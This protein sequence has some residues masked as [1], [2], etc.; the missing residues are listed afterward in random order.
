MIRTV[1][2]TFFALISISLFSQ[3]EKVKFGDIDMDDLAMEVYPLDSGAEAVYLIRKGES[4]LDEYD[5]MM[6]TDIHVRLKFLKESGLSRGDIE[7]QYTKG[8]N[9]IEKLKAAT[10]NL[11][12]GKMVKRTISKKEWVTEKYDN[13]RRSKKI[14]F[15]DVT[16]GSII[17]YTYRQKIGNYYNMPSWSFQLSIPTVYT[18]FKMNKPKY[19]VY[20]PRIKGYHAAAYVN[21]EG[22]LYHL[23]MKDVPSLE[24]EPYVSTIENFRSKIE[25]ELKAWTIPGEPTQ[26]FLQ[27]WRV[28][29][30]SLLD[31]DGLG[32]AIKKTGQLK[33]IYPA[34]KQWAENEESLKGIY[35]YIRD[36]FEWN[37]YVSYRVVDRSKK[38]W[39]EAKGD[40]ADI[41]IL[42]A[43]FLEKAG[44]EVYPVVL[45]TRSHGYLDKNFPLIKQFNYLI[46]GVIF[47]GKKILLDAT[48]KFRPYNVL[49]TRAMNGEGLMIT[50]FGG[51]WIDLRVNRE[52]SSKVVSLEFNFDEDVETL[53]G[54]A[55]I[56]FKGT[57]ASQIRRGLLNEKQKA[58]TEDSEDEEGDSDVLEDYKTGDVENLEYN[59]LEIPDKSLT[60][61]YDFSSEADINIIG[62]KIFVSP[63]LLKVADENPF[64]LEK[65]LFPIEIPAPTA[66]TY[67]FKMKVPEG[68]EVEELPKSMNMVLP[69]KGG[70]YMFVAGEQNG[71]V[72]VMIRMNLSK[73]MYLPS[74]YP[75]F[76][77]LFNQIVSK[78]QEQIVLKEK[79][80]Q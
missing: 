47:N 79:A 54:K 5:G 77:E 59:N 53:E 45:S 57:I 78:Q 61:N 22:N 8:V 28:I 65:R 20:L 9:E 55:Q 75:A 24:R 12:D 43:Q 7:L 10:Y 6:V 64:K 21:T 50:E 1:L 62:D 19:G 68:Y 29:N 39:E 27:N 35:E 63:I 44:F 2:V 41:N 80:D 14:S 58:E 69:D 42:L 38:L 23:V 16:V 66:D 3:V 15:P 34:D 36:H 67:I 32:K 52:A 70:K 51:E 13:D 60:I 33:K 37:G 25:F 26:A 46:V 17:E 11:V 40:N 4:F 74:D 49:P 71:Y 48:D 31:S 72:Q 73:T 18:E 56:N 76:K 30:K